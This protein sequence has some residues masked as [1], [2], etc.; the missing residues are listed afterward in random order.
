MWINNEMSAAV[1]EVARVFY[2]DMTMTARWNE[3]RR[4]GEPRLMTGWCWEAKAPQTGHRTGIKTV[5]AAY[6]DAWYA[7]VQRAEPPRIGRARS[8][9]R[10]VADAERR[11]A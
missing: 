3:H 1:D 9:L 11:V 5:T 4:D 10:V 2:I 6:I 7:L 8:R